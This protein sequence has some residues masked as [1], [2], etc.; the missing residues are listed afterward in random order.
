MI[1][2]TLRLAVRNLG[3]NTR[4]TVLSAL[5]VGIGC[6]VALVFTGF[7]ESVTEVYSRLAAESG[8]GDLRVGPVGWLPLRSD[9]T[10]LEGGE[11]VL[12]RVRALKGVA[13]AAPRVRVQGLLAMGTHVAGVELV[14]VDPKVEQQSFRPVRRVV[15]GR[16]LAPGDGAVVVLGSAL[17]EQL[18]VDVDDQL[19]VTVVQADGGME[20]ALLTVVGVVGSGSRTMDL[21]LAQVPLATASALTGKPG[22]AEIAIMLDDFAAV[23]RMQP[24]VQA[25]AGTNEVLRWNQVSVELARHLQQDAAT[26]RLMGGVV[27]LVV[28][29][30]VASAQLTAAL[31]RRKEFAVLAAIGMKPWRL[32]TQLMLE[33]LALGLVGAGVGFAIGLPALVYL[34]THGLNLSALF[35]SNM[36]FEGVIMDPILRARMGWWMVPYTLEL[37]VAA[38]LV[39]SIYPAIYAARTDP[40]S[41][42]RSAA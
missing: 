17:A 12:A 28:L 8:P 20:S 34:S 22:I 30:G 33:A 26:S 2:S 10:R 41:A 42:L 11:A 24:Q 23:D 32:V 1:A 25:V 39:G 13:V 4:R 14:G 18:T 16:Y 7:R 3:R 40:A 9:K 5:G 21:A 38:T 35:S 15:K 29:L 31:E 36:T 27:I 19:V 37:A 6:A